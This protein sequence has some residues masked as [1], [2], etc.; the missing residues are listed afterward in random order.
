[1]QPSVEDVVNMAKQP[2]LSDPAMQEILLEKL[3]PVI[4]DTVQYKTEEVP[5]PILI[6]LDEVVLLEL[7]I[8]A[9][10][11]SLGN[12]VQA[13]AQTTETPV[14]LAGMLGLATVATCCQKFF[15]VQ[16]APGYTEPLCLW[17]VAALESGNR[18]TA[19]LLKMTAPLTSHERDLRAKGEADRAAKESERLTVE[20]RVKALRAKVAA[21]EDIGDIAGLKTELIE[22]EAKM[23]AAPTIPQLWAQDVTP[24]KLGPLMADNGEAMALLSDEGG[25]FEMMAG[26]YSSKGVPN[27]DLYLQ[28]HAGS[29]VRVDR[30]SRPQVD[31]A[32]P[33]LTIG[34]SPQP[35]VLRGLADTAGFRERGLLARFL[36]ALPASRLG[37]RSLKTTPVPETV[38]AQYVAMIKALLLIDLPKDDSGRIVPMALHL[39]PEAHREWQEFARAVE[40]NLRPGGEFE[41]LKDWAGKLPGAVLRV[42]GLF[43]CV[44]Y[45]H[46]TPQNHK[47]SFA[48]L[49]KALTLLA[50]LAKH[51]IAVFDLM[52]ADPALDGA[53]KV[54]RW[55]QRERKDS[56]TAR[57]CYQAL[58]GSYT[59]MAL[60]DPAFKLL[61]ERGQLVPIESTYTGKG[62]PPSQMY[63]VHSDLTKGWI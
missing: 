35:S 53:R 55:V 9:F 48:T 7:P 21:S 20:A 14:E 36:Y 10:P 19:V 39:S 52:G 34:I 8:E 47:I 26:R 22:L 57:D 11:E 50:V 15:V 40:I 18:K 13:V 17:T 30:G 61:C 51:T 31:L 54:M 23:P 2:L 6:P 44:T 59:T 63:N 62:R 60:L 25:L 42:A 28:S 46:S 32:A 3:G 29:P 27:L 49:N 24:E 5:P 12:M 4:G 1:M 37:Y 41:Y 58:R 56:F 38:A 33:T 43:H 45:A 16:G